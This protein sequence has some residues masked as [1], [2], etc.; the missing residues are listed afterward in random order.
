MCLSSLNSR[1]LSLK[2][3]E[4]IKTT[5]SE[6]CSQE[7]LEASLVKV[8]GFPKAQLQDV[9]TDGLN[10]ML[11]KGFVELLQQANGSLIYRELDPDLAIKL[12]GL[13]AEEQ[14]PFL[15]RHM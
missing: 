4:I 10:H 15:Y 11:T 13:S 3:F 8:D 7:L 2:L 14:V 9:I 6:G 12:R 5:G 1:P